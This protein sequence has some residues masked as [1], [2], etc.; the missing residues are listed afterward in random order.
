MDTIGDNLLRVESRLG[1]IEGQIGGLLREMT[2][3]IGQL[4]QHLTD[5]RVIHAA[6]DERLLRAIKDVTSEMAGGVSRL[7]ERVDRVEKNME[8]QAGARRMADRW[9]LG[10]LS[11]F[12]AASGYLGGW[13]ARWPGGHH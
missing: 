8:N 1:N 9:R 7:G 13:F 3:L 10:L 2:R 4:D 12:S 6:Q 5:D 11:A